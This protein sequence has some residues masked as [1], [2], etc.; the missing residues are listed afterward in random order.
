MS[1]T[2]NGFEELL[3]TF[4]KIEQ[5]IRFGI[6]PN[7]EQ[8]VENK[9]LN[10]YNRIIRFAYPIWQNTDKKLKENIKFTLVD[11]HHR[12]GVSLNLLKSDIEIPTFLTTE[13]KLREELQKVQEEN[14]NTSEM[15]EVNELREQLKKMEM[16]LQ[17][18]EER[19]QKNKEQ[20]NE[21]FEDDHGDIVTEITSG[22]QI[23]LESYR[24][25]PEFS[26]DKGQYR[27]WR[28]QV[29]RRMK[30][31]DKFMTHPKYEAALGIIRAK[32][33][34][35]ASNVLTN[36]RTAYN[37]RAM[38]LTLDSTYSDQRPLYVVEAEMT[39]IRQSGKTLQDYYNDI[40]SA[41]NLVI[42]KI[43]FDYRGKLEHQQ[44]LMGEMQRKAVRTFIIGLASLHTRHI[45]Y[46]RTPGTL[47]EAFAI[48]QTVYYDYQHLQLERNNIPQKQFST[49]RANANVYY[50]KPNN[51]ERMK[52]N[53][54]KPTN[55]RQPNQ[56]QNMQ[57][58]RPQTREYDSSRQFQ[59][60]SNK[61]QRVNHLQDEETEESKNDS[62]DTI[63]DDLISNAA[64]EEIT[65]SAF[66]EQ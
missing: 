41:L 26:G 8:Q 3:E 56:Q 2:I 1:F 28:N 7:S 49:T 53:E 65:S 16:M 48:A 20:F 62:D 51:P 45:L 47:A 66:L 9:I 32:I 31:I 4:K 10:A 42:S 24:S 37:I 50:N 21:N 30:M 27:S 59:Q 15:A 38:I 22:D 17:A 36:N 58:S 44:A 29:G 33:T 23:Q 54:N 11:I 40:N 61:T 6:T 25:I 13:I 35:P 5:E 63:P 55:W 52:M 57:T 39:S 34:G 64:D 46:G 18:S 14:S 19:Q 12:L 43:S 60:Y